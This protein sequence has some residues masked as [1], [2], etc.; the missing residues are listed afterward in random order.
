MRCV[1]DAA[2]DRFVDVL[3]RMA[4]EIQSVARNVPIL[5]ATF[6]SSSDI[7]RILRFTFD[8][9][10]LDHVRAFVLLSGHGPCPMSSSIFV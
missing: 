10:S 8:F 7:R 6:H 2:I 1:S 4:I 3:L 5:P 9:L